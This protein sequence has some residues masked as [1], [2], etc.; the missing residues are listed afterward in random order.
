M[1]P[2]IVEFLGSRFTHEQYLYWSRIEGTLWTAADIV[3]AFQMIRLG[4][5]ARGYV[6]SRLHRFS[7]LVLLATLPAA[8][9]I[10]FVD[11]GG[12]FFR[13]ELG[14]TIPHF[15]IILYICAADAQ[16][17]LRALNFALARREVTKQNDKPGAHHEIPE[18]GR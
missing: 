11:S 17:G 1:W 16:I 7:Y 13:L 14:V 3:I 18:T 12:L 2:E 10:P 6:G 8:A 15:L 5:L 9:F 4:N